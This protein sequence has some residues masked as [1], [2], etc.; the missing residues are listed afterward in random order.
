MI[1]NGFIKI[2]IVIYRPKWWKYESILLFPKSPPWEEW[3]GRFSIHHPLGSPATLNVCT[4]GFCTTCFEKYNFRIISLRR[5][6][7]PC[8]NR[9]DSIDKNQFCWRW[10]LWKSK[11]RTRIEW[12]SGRIQNPPDGLP[13]DEI[14]PLNHLYISFKPSLSHL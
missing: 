11:L 4:W 12:V 3:R 2:D 8:L 6:T 9:I 5:S 13:H 1:N 10:G 7:M 14:P